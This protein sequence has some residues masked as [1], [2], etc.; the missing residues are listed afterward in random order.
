MDPTY[1]TFAAQA[2]VDAVD[3]FLAADASSDVDLAAAS[4]TEFLLWWGIV[5]DQF[6]KDDK[7]WDI[8]LGDALSFAR[9]CSA[10]RRIITHEASGRSW[11]RD[12]PRRWEARL[13]WR[14]TGE[15]EVGAW[16]LMGE[17]VQRERAAYDRLLSQREIRPVA[18][19]CQVVLGLVT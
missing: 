17:G 9:N 6:P 19:M 3:R 4:A 7:P 15:V 10:H 18:E 2:G 12:R 8:E 5:G 11:P 14:A 13:F 1:V 16:N